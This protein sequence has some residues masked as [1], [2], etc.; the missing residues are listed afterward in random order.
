MI[1]AFRFLEEKYL[2]KYLT[3]GRRIGYNQNMQIEDNLI[4]DDSKPSKFVKSDSR[5]V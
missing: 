5:P 2:K 3:E 4:R 1:E